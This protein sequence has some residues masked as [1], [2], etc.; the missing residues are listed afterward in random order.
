MPQNKALIIIT[1]GEEDKEKAVIGMRVAINLKKN[2][3]SN[4]VNVLFFGPSE[5]LVAKGDKEVDEL[6]IQ[7]FDQKIIPTA[8]KGIAIRD[9][10]NTKLLEK[11]LELDMASGYIARRLDSGFSVITF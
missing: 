3:L 5:R 11:K 7:L 1:S 10:I 9:E 2:G 6:L 8:C 4:E